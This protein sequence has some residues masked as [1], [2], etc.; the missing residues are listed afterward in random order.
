MDCIWAISPVI[1]S[2]SVLRQGI[3]TI[4]RLTRK[5]LCWPQ[6]FWACGPPASALKA[7]EVIGLCLWLKM[8]LF[9]FVW[10]KNHPRDWLGSREKPYHFFLFSWYSKPR[11]H[12]AVGQ[13]E[14]DR[15][16]SLNVKCK[17]RLICL[18]T[19]T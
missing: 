12:S 3:I 1:L 18:N 2:F 16:Y 5:S 10:I 15:S 4:C 13:A 7:T 8:S 17:Y 14:K 9:F 11:D 6:G 19:W